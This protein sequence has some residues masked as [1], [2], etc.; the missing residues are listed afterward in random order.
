M[1]ITNTVI[2]C[3]RL[4][5]Q[6]DTD[7]GYTEIKTTI[8]DTSQN[9]GCFFAGKIK[10]V[11]EENK[12]PMVIDICTSVD[13]LLEWQSGGDIIFYILNGAIDEELQILRELK[14]KHINSNVILVAADGR[15]IKEAYKVQP[16]RYLYISDPV[17]EIQEAVISAIHESRERRGFILESDGKYINVLLK[18]VLYIEALGDDIGIT[19]V[20]DER[21]IIRMTLKN[22]HSLLG[23]EFIR[24]SRQRIVNPEHIKMLR[25]EEVILDD[26]ERIIIST[27]ERRKVEELYVEYISRLK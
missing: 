26:G 11:A 25:C 27:R 20:R 10:L 19:T 18:D 13:Q 8:F 12:I 5:N 3:R 14:R 16:F 6:K 21:Y 22:M 9:A 23:N 4:R 7:F 24:V 15:Y 1:H 2:R 17:E